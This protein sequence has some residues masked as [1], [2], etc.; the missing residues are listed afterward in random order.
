VIDPS[1]AAPV[2]AG[3][4]ISGVVTWA[5]IEMI[6]LF[7]PIAGTWAFI[8]YPLYRQLWLIQPASTFGIIGTGMLVMMINYV[9]ALL[10]IGWMDKKWHP[11]STGAE[12]TPPLKLGLTRRWS[13]IGGSILAGWI[14]LSLAI[15]NSSL[16]T[17]EIKIAVV[18]P[19]VSPIVSINR[20]A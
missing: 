18:Q 19:E 12:P 4:L 3:S 14:V 16:D 1:T 2:K 6:R 11:Q 15:W 17:P 13:I 8:A 10:V 9:L 5:A 7:I 20:G